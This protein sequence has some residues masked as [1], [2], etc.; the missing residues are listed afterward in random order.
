MLSLDEALRFADQQYTP[1]SFAGVI[2]NAVRRLQA[3]N[4]ELRDAAGAA[5]NLLADATCESGVCMC[6]DSVIGH[7][8]L[9]VGH[10][11]CDS[12]AYHQDLLVKRLQAILDRGQPK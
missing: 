8:D 5:A 10:T 6:G 4:A 3:E 11:A 9:S 12:G 1:Q 7:A 2:A